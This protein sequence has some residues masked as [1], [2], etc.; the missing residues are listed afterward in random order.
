[1]R[2]YQPKSETSWSNRFTRWRNSTKFLFQDTYVRR[3][4]HHFASFLTTKSLFQDAYV[5]GAS[6]I[7]RLFW[8][9][10]RDLWGLCIHSAKGKE[11]QV[12]E[13][14]L[15]TAK[16]RMTPLKQLTIPRLELQTGMEY[17]PPVWRRLFKRS[18]EFSSK[19]FCSSQTAQLC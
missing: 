18:L 8:R 5:L 16:S 17:L 11:W 2:S 14:N 7:V 13:V 10:P 6:I 12:L 19:M 3:S 9:V 15:I 4:K 1:M